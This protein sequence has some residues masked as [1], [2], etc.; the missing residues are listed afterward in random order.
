[1]TTGKMEISGYVVTY[2]KVKTE[3]L[4]F[5]KQKKQPGD[6]IRYTYPPKSQK[7]R[8]KTVVVTERFIFVWRMVFAANKLIDT[9]L[10]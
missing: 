4:P 6:Q 9:V 2:T 3:A 1:M 8:V 10:L 5:N 7:R